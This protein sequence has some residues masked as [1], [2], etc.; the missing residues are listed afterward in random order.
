MNFKCI[1]IKN[2]FKPVRKMSALDAI[3]A[4]GSF[5]TDTEIRA[6]SCPCLG[7][8]PENR[9]MVKDALEKLFAICPEPL[10]AFDAKKNKPLVSLFDIPKYPGCTC[11]IRYDALQKRLCQTIDRYA[12]LMTKPDIACTCQE[13]FGHKGGGPLSGKPFTEWC[14]GCFLMYQKES[15][16]NTLV[17]LVLNYTGTF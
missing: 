13:Q 12:I 4:F 16:A 11:R 17:Y 14:Q 15:V 3:G 8:S 5:F 9:L 6:F 7:P 2:T 10:P 1:I